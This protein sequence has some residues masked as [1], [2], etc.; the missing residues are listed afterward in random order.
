MHGCLRAVLNRVWKLVGSIPAQGVR[1]PRKKARKPSC[2][3]RKARYSLCD[4]NIA[5]TDEI[6]GCGFA[7]DREVTTL[8]WG[9]IHSDRIE[10]VERFCEGEFDDTETDAGRGASRLIPPEFCVVRWMQ[11]GSAQSIA[12]RGS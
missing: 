6:R 7:V 11:L 9:R 1:L 8:R 12:I 10:I 2:C 3:T 4:R 5:R